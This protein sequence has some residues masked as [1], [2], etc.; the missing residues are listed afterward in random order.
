MIKYNKKGAIE[1]SIS[2][3]VIIVIGMSM[4]ILGLVL[5]RS[6]FTSAQYNV[7][8]LGKNVEAEITKLFNEKGG[9]TY[10]Y[11]PNNQVDIKKGSVFGVGF[12]IKNDVE[13]DPA[14][15]AFTWEIKASDISK[16]C[17]LTLAQADNYLIL[18]SKGTVSLL[19]GSDPYIARV[20]I[21]PSSTA[22]LCEIKYDFIVNKDGQ[23]Y[24]TNYFIVKI[25][26]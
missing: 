15:G 3:V 16:N 7:D 8:Q 4:L 26:G 13:G 9:K 1:L 23:P 6:I 17:K 11:L 25:T 20:R 5:V 21:Q 19:P 10:V 14:A 18:G 12:G 2:T 24:E 22:P